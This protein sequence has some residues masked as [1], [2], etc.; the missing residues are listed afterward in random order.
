MAASPDLWV[1]VGADVGAGA[2]AVVGVGAG[3]GLAQEASSIRQIAKAN[4]M[5]LDILPRF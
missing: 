2:G 4:Q 1:T 5:L 3:T